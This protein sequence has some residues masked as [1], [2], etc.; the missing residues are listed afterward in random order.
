MKQKRIQYDVPVGMRVDG[1]PWHLRVIK[2]T[3]ADTGPATAILGGMYGDKA[4]SCLA[5]HHLDRR[6]AETEHLAGT[7]IL[8]PRPS[9]SPESRSTLGSTLTTWH[10]IAVSPV[11]V[12]DFSPI[13]SLTP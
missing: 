10:S 7:V 4:M 13:S 5:L 8:S 1:T 9:T 6:L 2:H 3:G 11:R 12:R